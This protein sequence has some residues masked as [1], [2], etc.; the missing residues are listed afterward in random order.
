MGRLI[1]FDW[2]WL[3]DVSIHCVQI[4]F[5]KRHTYRL[6]GHFSC[7]SNWLA[8]Q[9]YLDS[10]GRPHGT[11]VDSHARQRER[12]IGD[13]PDV[14]MG[15]LV[16]CSRAI[17]LRKRRAPCSWRVQNS[18]WTSQRARWGVV[19]HWSDGLRA[20][21]SWYFS[22]FDLQR[23]IHVVTFLRDGCAKG[24]KQRDVQHQ[25][26]GYDGWS[27]FSNTWDSEHPIQNLDHLVTALPMLPMHR[28]KRWKRWS[29]GELGQFFG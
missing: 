16:P 7:A 23:S 8:L 24:W 10:L 28:S 5:A 4:D 19:K 17:A 14:A 2:Y 11:A 29:G 22:S 13:V 15:P 18:W 6:P 20:D 21:I 3:I 9:C 27:S 25:I 26:H 12:E 1:G